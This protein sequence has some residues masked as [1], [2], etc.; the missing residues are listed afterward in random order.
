MTRNT[1]TK[2]GAVGAACLAVGAGAGIL[3]SAGAKEG[4]RPHGARHAQHA[5]GY[6]HRL[7][8]AVHAEAVVPTQQ[9][10]RTITLDR[11]FLT[12]RDGAKLTL[13]QG[14]RTQTW[15]TQTFTVPADAKVRRDRA[16][17]TLDALQTGDVVRIVAGAKRT[18]VL[19]HAPKTK[20][21]R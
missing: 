10:F 9:G 6:A 11:G 4:A 15:R 16:P 1:I 21:M 2:T 14:T 8:R 20:T 5:H 18:R 12:A 17:A 19:A 3:G 7:A 13:R